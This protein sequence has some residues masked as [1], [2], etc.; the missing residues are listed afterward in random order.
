MLY[1]KQTGSSKGSAFCWYASRA[2]ADRATKQFNERHLLPDPSGQQQRPLVVRP[3]TVRRSVPR[4]LLQAPGGGGMGLGA[5]GMGAMGAAGLGVLGMGGGVHQMAG[6]VARAGAGASA[7]GGMGRIMHPIVLQQAGPDG[8]GAG[9]S[10]GSF[11]IDNS[12][13]FGAPGAGESIEMGMPSGGF[14]VTGGNSGPDS[15]NFA[16]LTG[17]GSM[18]IN[19]ASSAGANAGSGGSTGPGMPWDQQMAGA[20]QQLQQ[21]QYVPM[22]QQQALPS[23]PRSGVT[24]GAGEVMTLQ[25]PLLASQLNAV[26]PHVFNIQGASGAEVTTHAVAPGVFCLRL[27]GSKAAVDAASTLISH[28]I[29]NTA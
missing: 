11:L 7:P 4:A 2:D 9:F 10:G 15:G 8:P 12:G 19:T 17:S 23:I 22:P 25:V 26:T 27:S 18:A 28:V 21:V 1:D 3:A 5:G 6:R 29:Q 14:A 24:G 16:V 20:Q 13:A